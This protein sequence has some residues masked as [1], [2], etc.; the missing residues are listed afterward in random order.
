[1]GRQCRQLS[2]LLVNIYSSGS[3]RLAITTPPAERSELECTG[4]SGVE[5]KH[6][7]AWH[8]DLIESTMSKNRVDPKRVGIQTG[9]TSQLKH[10]SVSYHVSSCM[11]GEKLLWAV[12]W[13]RASAC[14]THCIGLKGENSTDLTSYRSYPR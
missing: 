3:Q 10:P 8:D 6:R 14:L 11:L 9:W 12:V 1:M 5:P 13:P 7:I 2:G 4:S